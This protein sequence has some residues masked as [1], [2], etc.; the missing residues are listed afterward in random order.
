MDLEQTNSAI[1][2]AKRRGNRS[3]DGVE[4]L[5]RLIAE[6][7][8]G[9]DIG[10]ACRGK[11]DGAG[12][13]AMAKISAMA[14]AKFAGCRYFHAPFTSMSHA[15][16]DRQDWA[17]RWEAFLDL[18][19]GER[20]VPEDAEPVPLAAAVQDPAL[21]AG[22]PVVIVERMFHLPEAA[23]WRIRDGLRDALRA[24]YWGSP[25]AAI[26]SHRAPAGLTAAIHLR[27]GDVNPSSHAERYV[28]NEV[29]LRHIARLREAIVPFGRPLTIN[30][31]SEGAAEDFRAFADAGCN[32]HIGADTFETFH[33]MVTADILMSATSMFSYLAGLLSRGV[34]LDHRGRAPELANWLHRRPDGSIPVKRL[35]RAL[36]ERVGWVEQA[37]YRVRLWRR[38]WTER[39]ADT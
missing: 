31:Y 39:R 20:P 27:R 25:K 38:R 29:V 28:R 26:P 6:G 14:V 36:L 22:R 5:A 35:R 34:V 2:H 15:A 19:A 9:P 21:Y 33:N 30:L 12:A 8:L 16:G 18:G 37:R 7:R 32:L 17:G 24:K 13:Q 10:V 4:I 11:V 1:R 3:R 23:G